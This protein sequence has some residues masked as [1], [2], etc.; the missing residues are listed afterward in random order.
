MYIIDGIA[1]A[2]EPH[3]PPTVSGVRPMPDHRLWVRFNSGEERVFD[4]KPLLSRPAFAPLSD[5]CLF[6]EV[7]IDCGVPTWQNGE[8]DIDPEWLLRDGALMRS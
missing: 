4:F 3:R 5:V 1:Y 2:G 8:I 7:Y 6:N